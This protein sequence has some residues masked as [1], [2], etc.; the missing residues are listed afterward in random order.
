MMFFVYSCHKQQ[1]SND[2]THFLLSEDSRR[3]FSIQEDSISV[4]S[5]TGL[6]DIYKVVRYRMEPLTTI[7]GKLGIGESYTIA[8]DPSLSEYSFNLTVS[9][10]NGPETIG[11]TYQAFN[12]IGTHLVTQKFLTR[13]PY[14]ITYFHYVPFEQGAS[15]LGIREIGDTII[16]KRQ[17]H[18]IFVNR[19]DNGIYNEGQAIK[20]IY[21]SK[22]I[23]FIAFTTKSSVMWYRE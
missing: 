18:D 5:N 20:E 13:A 3:W 11:I 10:E 16:N 4:K 21:I 22:S 23:G 9:N 17:Y 2:R 7:N 14:S 8:M 12:S 6:S 19:I 1:D 15:S